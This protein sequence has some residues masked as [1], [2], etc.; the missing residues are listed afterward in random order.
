[1]SKFKSYPSGAGMTDKPAF[2]QPIVAV[3][4]D[5][6]MQNGNRAQRRRIA[7]ELVKRKSRQRGR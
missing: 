3:N 2:Q 1:M 6:V 7:R 5:W 4:V